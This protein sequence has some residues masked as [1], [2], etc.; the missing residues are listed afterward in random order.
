MSTT[1]KP[2]TQT[3]EAEVN[4]FAINENCPPNRIANGSESKAA[5]VKITITKKNKIVFGGEKF[6]SA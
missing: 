2:V 1:D 6:I 3:A 5:P 4:R